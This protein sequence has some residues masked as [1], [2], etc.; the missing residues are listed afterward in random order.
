MEPSE[1]GTKPPASDQLNI[2]FYDPTNPSQSNPDKKIARPRWQ[3]LADRIGTAAQTGKRL[4]VVA[5]LASFTRHETDN[6]VPI[7]FASK[8]SRSIN[9]ADPEAA[10]QKLILV[11]LCSVLSTSGRAA[12]EELDNIMNV[13]LKSTNTRYLDRAKRGAK[14]ANEIIAEW[15]LASPSEGDPIQRLDRATHAILQGMC[16]FLLPLEQV[17]GRSGL[18]RE[19]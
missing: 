19:Y 7:V 18:I 17:K 12:P 9:A 5:L 8:L 2:I 15:A 10:V 14:M 3:Q 1:S 16:H 4:D 13:L 11:S 6:E